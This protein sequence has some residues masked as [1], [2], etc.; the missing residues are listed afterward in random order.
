[1]KIKDFNV[2]DDT[3]HVQI[4]EGEALGIQTFFPS[5]FLCR[6][7][8]AMIGV[9][10]YHLLKEGIRDGLDMNALSRWPLGKDLERD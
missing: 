3:M 1:M 6:D 7:N 5:P 2:S 10:G 9:A 8:A 4:V